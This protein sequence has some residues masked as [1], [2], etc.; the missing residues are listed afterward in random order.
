ME[1][2]QLLPENE[3]PSLLMLQPWCELDHLTAG[4]T[5]R[6]AFNTALHVGDAPETVINNRKRVV[7]QLGWPFEAFTCAEQVHGNNVYLVTS[8][9]AGR[10]RFDRLSAIA[11]TDALITNVPG[12]LLAMYFADCVPLYFYDPVTESIGLAHAGW[13][14]TVSEIAVKTVEK[15]T[16]AFGTE[17][18]NLMA[19]IGP[20]IGASCYEV[21]ESV[22]QHVRPLDDKS[23]IQI[24]PSSDRAQLDLKHLNR[25]LMIKA[26][27]MPS[28]IEMSSWCTGCR[29]DLLFSHRMENG[30]TGRMMSW[31]GKKSR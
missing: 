19:A 16:A 5:T 27:I 17:P 22:L 30:T 21:D 1:P 2:F 18:K 7:E 26:G 12:V 29:T 20:S 28:R 10:G 9:D 15:M 4:F 25:H 3:A 14:G 8:D 24:S 13:K 11:D 6:H 23:I 31:L